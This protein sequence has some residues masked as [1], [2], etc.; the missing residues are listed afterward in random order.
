MTMLRNKGLLDRKI[1]G[2]AILAREGIF[3]KTDAKALPHPLMK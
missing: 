1:G 3:Y 2:H